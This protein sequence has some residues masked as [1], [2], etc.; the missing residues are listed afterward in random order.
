MANLK[1]LVKDNKDSNVDVVSPVSEDE[2]TNRSLDYEKL[3]LNRFEKKYSHSPFEGCSIV[4]E[5]KERIIQVNHCADPFC[6][7]FGLDQKRYETIK[8]KPSR[9]KTVSSSE[10]KRLLCNDIDDNDVIG[11]VTKSANN[12]YSNWAIAQEIKRLID[13]NTVVDYNKK[14]YFHRPD[15]IHQ[16]A[17]PSNNPKYFYT[18]GKSSSNSQKYQCKY[19]KKFTNVLPKQEECFSYLQK[20]NDT[21]NLFMRLVINRTPVTRTMEIAG[22][23]AST[24]YNKIEWLFRKCLEFL[25]R[26]ETTPLMEK[27]FNTLW[28]ETDK[29]TYNLNNVRKKGHRHIGEYKEEIQFPTH[30]IATSDSYSRYVF[31][32]DIAYDY[33]HNA[34]ELIEDLN[35]YGENRIYKYAQKNSHYRHIYPEKIAGKIRNGYIQN[36]N[37][38]VNISNIENRANYTDGFHVVSTYTAY[39]Q[40][41]LINEMLNVD[42][43]NYITDEDSSIITALM[44][45]YSGGIRNRQVNVFTC[46]VDKTLSK[47]DAYMEYIEARDFLKYIKGAL[48]PK[49]KMKELAVIVLE[50]MLEVDGLYDLHVKNNIEYAEKREVTILHPYPYKD[51]GRRYINCCTDLSHLSNHEIAKMLYN[52]NMRSINT[53]FNKIRRKISTLERPLFSSRGEG[54]SY[55]YSNYNPKYAHYLTTI[56]RTYHNFCDTFKHKGEDVTPAM[57]LGIADRPYKMALLVSVVGKD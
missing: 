47:R 19:C 25:E 15:C 45:A 37:D 55:I 49:K 29:F 35:K 48:Y 7:W 4:I 13:I 44:R 6:K 33:T 17:T 3:A 39:A 21:L 27:R 56:H 16:A 36:I 28:L 14:Y 2:I 26:H 5:G 18:R 24:Y 10:N 30:I 43:I 54:V 31:R 1:I 11:T 50:G 46:R 38:E 34:F 52:V 23:G 12:L 57:M 20:R 8:Y 22:I 9:Y 53:Y 51:E 41:W 42:T 32:T 40:Y